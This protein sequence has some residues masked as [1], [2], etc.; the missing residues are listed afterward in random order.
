MEVKTLE[1]G[2]HKL[3]SLEG[4]VRLS[5]WEGFQS[6]RGPYNSIDSSKDSDGTI[7]I[8]VGEY[9]E[10][11]SLLSVSSEQVNAYNLTVKQQDRIKENIL[12]ALLLTYKQWRQEYGN[13][14]GD[15]SMPSVTLVSQF[16]NLI[17]LSAV[18]VLNVIK[19]GVAYVGYEFGC[20]WDE[21]HGLGIMTHNDRVIEI[22]AADTSFESW[23]AEK[24]IDPVKAEQELKNAKSFIL[25]KHSK[26]WWKIW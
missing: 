14:E 15:E 1:T 7:T 2:H 5:A 16:E 23:I 9:V 11:E 3:K 17:G 6:R 13:G 20:S 26:P 21:E 24:D 18:H 10:A 4:T 25:P 12:N 19:D 22:G 8:T